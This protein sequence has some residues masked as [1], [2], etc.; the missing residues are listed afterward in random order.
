MPGPLSQQLR[1]NPFL[2]AGDARLATAL[3]TD[4]T[5]ATFAALRARRDQF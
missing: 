2:Q 4:G 5:L 3:G 1:V